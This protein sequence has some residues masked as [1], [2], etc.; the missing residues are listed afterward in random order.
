MSTVDRR[1][2]GEIGRTPH[3]PLRDAVPRKLP[4]QTNKTRIV[5]SQ[6]IE[7]DKKTGIETAL[8]CAR[9]AAQRVSKGIN[10]LEQA[11]PLY[12]GERGL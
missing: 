1:R 2:M 6:S 11:R 4:R 12:F 7:L 5:H 8:I 9:K 10:R 3:F